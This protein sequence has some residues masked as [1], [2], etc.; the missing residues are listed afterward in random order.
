MSKGQEFQNERKFMLDEKTGTRVTRLTAFPTI[1]ENLYMHDN[2]F[3]PDSKTLIFKSWS[4]LTRGSPWDLFKVNTD[5]TGL[6]Q[7]TDGPV[8]GPLVSF[9]ERA[10]F[11]TRD[12]KMVKLELDT[13][14][15]TEL[16]GLPDEV[17]GCGQPSMTNDSRFYLA[18]SSLKN[19]KA[20]ATLFDLEKGESR[21]VFEFDGSLS[22]MQVEPSQMKYI[23]YQH[24]PLPGDT[25]YRNIW[26]VDIDG[27]NARELPLNYG[28]GHWM[29]HG[30]GMRIMSALDRMRGIAICRVDDGFNDIVTTMPAW[31]AGSSRDGHWAVAD[32]N[33]PDMGLI[34]C[35]TDTRKTKPVCET[36]GTNCNPQ[37]THPHPGLSP[38]MRYVVFSSD[39]FGHPDVY[40]AELTDE[41]KAGL[42]KI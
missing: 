38:D 27:T 18:Q 39:R 8:G 25:H 42:A 35:N 16:C 30:D 13:L 22:H 34:L 15:E 10:V 41:F 3:T 37:W 23:A 5:G 1:N 17:G 6:V 26:I 40:I 19:G 4:S 36:L 31:H 28:N 24:G 7:I 12:R 21:V 2:C 11:F 20:G 33:W 14:A 32:T 9:R 29:W